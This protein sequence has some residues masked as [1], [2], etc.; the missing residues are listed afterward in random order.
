MKSS[1]RC[2]AVPRD[3]TVS[4]IGFERR[5]QLLKGVVQ[6]GACRSGGR[7]HPFGGLGRGQSQ[8]VDQHDHGSVLNAEPPKPSIELVLSGDL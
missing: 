7:P 1:W 3:V 2:H 5:A 8:V 6:P 4:R